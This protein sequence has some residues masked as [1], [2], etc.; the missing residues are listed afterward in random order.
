MEMSY[1]RAWDLLNEINRIYRRDA[2]EGQVGDKSGGG[3]ILTPFVS[4][5]TLRKIDDSAES[6]AARSFRPSGTS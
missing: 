6:A 3:V 1:K 2:T 4:R 5:R